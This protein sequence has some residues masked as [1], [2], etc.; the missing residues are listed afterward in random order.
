MKKIAF[1]GLGHMGLP[2]ACNLVK[3]GFDVTGFDLNPASTTAFE[4]AGGSIAPT[5]SA[6]KSN[7]VFITM[8][9]R[10]EQ[11]KTVCLGDEGLFHLAAKGSLFID[12]SSI[13][14]ETAK[15]IHKKAA[16]LGLLSLDA[17]VSGGVMGAENATLTFMVGG[18]NESFDKASPIIE[19]MAK[20]IVHAGD[21]G[22][23]Q[24][25]KICNNMMLAISMVAVSEGFNL[26]KKLGLKQ[27]KLF[28]I[29]SSSSA[30]CWSMTSYCPVPGVIE[31]APSSHDYKPGF[32]TNMMLK[33]LRL[34]QD[35]ASTSKTPTPLGAHTTALYEQL[36]EQGSGELDF[37]AIINM[38]EKGG[39]NDAH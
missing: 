4:K 31:T 17:P 21:A 8:L 37:S 9:Q 25:A 32:T 34:S 18:T 6:L 26:A 3:A 15:T 22:T 5:L 7:E 16:A 29:S 13:D 20:K 10:G 1:I 14:V 35:A 12:S 28:E 38:I 23:G 24:A 27:E 33:D 11:V 2:M 19:K 36:A 30:Q 39:F